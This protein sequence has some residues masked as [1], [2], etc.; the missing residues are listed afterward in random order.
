MAVITPNSSFNYGDSGVQWCPLTVSSKRENG[1]GFGARITITTD[2]NNAYVQ[3]DCYVGCTGTGNYIEDSTNQ[4][5]FNW[6]T[7][8]ASTNVQNYTSVNVYPGVPQMVYSTSKTYA[9]TS[10]AQTKSCVFRMANLGDAGSVQEHN[11]GDYHA[12]FTFTIPAKATT[13]GWAEHKVYIKNANGTW[14]QYQT[15]IKNANGT[16]DKYKVYIKILNIYNRKM[17]RHFKC[18]PIFLLFF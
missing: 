3:V 11:S 13:P 2:D 7:N 17:G 10:S 8:N 5:Y 12:Y 16:W 1:Y 18:L 4:T 14:D 6:D 9:R 15:Y